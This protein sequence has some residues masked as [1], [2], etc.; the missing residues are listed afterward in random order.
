MKPS[1]FAAYIAQRHAELVK[2]WNSGAS[3]EGYAQVVLDDIVRKHLTS[4]VGI[5]DVGDLVQDWGDWRSDSDWGKMRELTYPIKFPA[6]SGAGVGVKQVNN[7]VDFL[8]NNNRF[9]WDNTSQDW[10]YKSTRYYIELKVESPETGKFGGMALLDA[11]KSDRAKVWEVAQHED[12]KAV[13]WR[14]RRYWVVMIGFS[15]A[16]VSDLKSYKWDFEVTTVN[17]PQMFVGIDEIKK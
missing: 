7:T 13:P 4:K 11:Y 5:D 1:T 2:G 9:V 14:R 15:P 12:K 10:S 16:Q 17:V 6:K 8:I 3:F